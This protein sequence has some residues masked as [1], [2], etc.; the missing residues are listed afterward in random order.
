M[1]K[2]G[3]S[4][5]DGNEGRISFKSDV[6]R[7]QQTRRVYRSA[8]DLTHK[9]E[10]VFR[11]K[12]AYRVVF[13]KDSIEMRMRL[14][15]LCERLM[16]LHPIDFGRKAEEILW[17]KVYYNVITLAKK[18]KKYIR[19]GSS[20]EC[21]YRTHLLAATGFYHHLLMRLQWEY[22][23]QENHIMDFISFPDQDQ[24][25]DTCM[26]AN[27]PEAKD[28]AQKA[29]HRCLIYLGDLARYRQE[30]EGPSS[31][32]L[33]QRF[34]HQALVLNPAMGMPHN[35]LGTLAGT[36]YQGLDAAYHYLRCW[37]SD[38][39]FDGAIANLEKVFE[40]NQ[41]RFHELP[42]SPSPDLP[43]ELQRPRD[44]KQF[45]IRFLY[46]QELFQPSN[47]T[48]TDT[49][50][51]LCQ[52]VLQGF[53]QCMLHGA[54][55]H[56]RQRDEEGR[57]SYLS[58][59]IIFKLVVL[60]LMSTYRLQKAGSKQTSTAVVFT[61]ALFSYIL[62]HLCEKLNNAV[63]R[64]IYPDQT[65]TAFTK[66]QDSGGSTDG[67]AS[68]ANTITPILSQD[69]DSDG[70]VKPAKKKQQ[71][72]KPKTVLK[73]MRRRRK[74]AGMGAHTSEESDL[75]EGEPGEDNQSNGSSGESGEER[76]LAAES[77]SDYFMDS[78]ELELDDEE[79][80]EKH[81]V[82]ED[83]QTPPPGEGEEVA[84]NIMNDIMVE[85]MSSQLIT[86]PAGPTHTPPGRRNIRL[87][88]SFDAYT[89]E[90]SSSKTKED[91][92]DKKGGSP[93]GSLQTSPGKEN[94]DTSVTSASTS[95]TELQTSQIPLPLIMEI[96]TSEG[97]LPVIKILTDWLRTNEDFIIK[98]AQSSQPL[99]ARLASLLN[100][101]PHEKSLVNQDWCGSIALRQLLE[102]ALNSGNGKTWYQPIPLTEDI[103]IWTMPPL[104]YLQK[105][106]KFGIH[107][108]LDLTAQEETVIR[109]LCLRQFG[110]YLSSIEGISLCCEDD[111][112]ISEAVDQSD[113]QE[114]D[115]PQQQPQDDESQGSGK[116][117]EKADD[118]ETRRQQVMRGMAQLRLQSEVSQL[119]GSIEPLGM[120][121][122]SPYLIPDTA[123]LS[124]QLSVVRSLVTTSRFIF[125][126]PKA[127]VSQLDVNKKYQ[128]KA[129]EAI[130][131]ME[132]EFQIGNRYL[133][134]QKDKE[135][136]RFD[137]NSKTK[138]DDVNVRTFC[139]IAE[140]AHFFAVR[141]GDPSLRSPANPTPGGMVT[142]LTHQEP[143]DNPRV[144][145]TIDKL[146]N[147]GVDVTTARDFQARW[148][149]HT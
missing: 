27:K 41:K 13:E 64:K 80:L 129:R 66:A 72:K 17:W 96:L 32:L 52:E 87:A 8:Q 135:S 136:L 6:E 133:R 116:P 124:N 14:R 98:T 130:K 109:V 61:L 126:I 123:V 19:S 36:R 50:P 28:W 48:S 112:F 30:F 82:H 103:A 92:Q 63:Y 114:D 121:T 62:N 137:D 10:S 120:D 102:G 115:E 12:Q 75:S 21:A 122:L 81:N 131:F 144:T 113:E 38:L 111:H 141:S 101:C 149:A 57:E 118:G 29:C 33:A 74:R 99:W 18:S 25:K 85:D 147:V 142:I 40:R 148:Q 88:P 104:Q 91:G 86:P 65:A 117:E 145:A 16:M 22:G 5:E 108:D 60:T 71:K 110:Y 119:E 43:A 97:L 132:K 94:K 51:S 37:L 78:Q 68:P 76:V 1:V 4:S 15:D 26:D 138:I 35:Q 23:L 77:D 55:P 3:D 79:A 93:M 58:N 2:V 105:K 39:R 44:I 89:K 107:H 143:S 125:I 54:V 139:S 24:V 42:S 69:V 140:C 56:A 47:K 45:L 49:L 146:L 31:C 134:A 20:L 9:L 70:T 90:T 127:V 73:A 106:M 11:H 67:R 95:P 59:D 128:S 53:H 46:L 100:M 83:F 7:L 84:L 34:Y